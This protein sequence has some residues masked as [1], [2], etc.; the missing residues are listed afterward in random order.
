MALRSMT[1]RRYEEIRRRPNEGRSLR[2]I[3]R[4]LGRSRRTVREVRDEERLLP[5]AP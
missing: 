1:V 4:A 3:A 2:Q 5:D